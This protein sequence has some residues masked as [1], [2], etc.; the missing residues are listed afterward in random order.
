LVASV[1]ETSAIEERRPLSNTVGTVLDPIFS[2]RRRLRLAPGATARVQLALIVADA[3]ER[4]LALAD[5]YRDPGTF[6]RVSSLAWTQA[7]VQLRHLGVTSDE[8][9]LFRAGDR[10]PYS[11]TLR[12]PVETPGRNRHFGVGHGIRAIGRSCSSGSIR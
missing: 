6:D 2:I 11:V 12:A 9:H 3:R 8:A 5:K 1:S 7:Q 10:I 4:A